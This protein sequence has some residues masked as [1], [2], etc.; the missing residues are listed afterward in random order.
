MK[1]WVLGSGSRGNAVLVEAANTRVLVDCGFMPR[2]LGARL[3]AVGAHPEEIH[4][5]VLTHEHEDHA[6]GAPAAVTKWGWSL[7]ATHG[8]IAAMPALGAAGAQGFAAGATVRVG[9]LVV[10]SVKIPHDAAAPVGL[11]VVDP[12]NGTRCGIATD[13]G[14]VP[15]AML[16]AFRDLDILVL[17]SNHD[18]T[19][20]ANGPY[21]RVLQ[22]RIASRTGHLSNRSAA[23]AARALSHR[24]LR[25]LVLAHVSE[26]NNTPS[27]ALETA[28]TALAGS[29]FRG[30]LHVAPQDAPIGPFAPVRTQV[31]VANQLELELLG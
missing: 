30:T 21:P 25:H 4:A 12:S 29:R 11:V 16:T 23:A 9:N 2:P 14:T 1:V 15:A 10:E 18:E 24:G 20:L 22:N 13:L 26:A 5:L 8:T 6:K 31:A 28:T 3:S 17:E 27:L 7:H 19:M